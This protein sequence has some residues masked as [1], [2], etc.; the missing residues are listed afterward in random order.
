MSKSSK[1]ASELMAKLGIACLRASP[2]AGHPGFSK[3]AIGGI[4][5]RNTT[6][7]L[8]WFKSQRDAEK[9]LQAT[10]SRC[11]DSK[12]TKAG[13]TVKLSPDQVVDLV[14]TIAFSLGITRIK[15]GDVATTFDSISR[16]VETAI[17]SMGRTATLK[18]MRAVV[19]TADAFELRSA[20]S[21]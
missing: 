21:R 7:E 20:L 17:A 19:A 15:G 3:L 10:L 6:G 12:K 2:L 9:V 14:T 5:D 16:R 11:L 8:V 1:L 18:R 4:A 13:I